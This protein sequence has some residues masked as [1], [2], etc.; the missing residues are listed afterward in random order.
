[1]D[2]RAR[3]TAHYYYCN[4]DSMGSCMS[5]SQPYQCDA[6]RRPSWGEWDSLPQRL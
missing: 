6:I 2:W 4:Y 3:C 5:F 1:M